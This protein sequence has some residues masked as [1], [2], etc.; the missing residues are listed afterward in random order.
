MYDASISNGS[1]YD[2]SS[3]VSGGAPT[4]TEFFQ[5]EHFGLSALEVRVP[6]LDI[7]KG[8]WVA[9]YYWCDQELHTVVSFPLLAIV[10]SYLS[11]TS[12]QDALRG[13][14]PAGGAPVRPIYEG[15]GKGA[16]PA[17]AAAEA[18]AT[19]AAQAHHLRDLALQPRREPRRRPRCVSLCFCFKYVE[20]FRGRKDRPPPLVGPQPYLRWLLVTQ[21][22]QVRRRRSTP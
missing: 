14:V 11:G 22:P 5:L 20:C 12:Q 6:C 2:G 10:L 7:K 19:A 4:G 1:P 17:Q 9:L 16:D 15:A 13:P 21:K 18:A 8:V 3:G